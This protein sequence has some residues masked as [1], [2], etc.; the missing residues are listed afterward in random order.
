MSVDELSSRVDEHGQ[1]LN[2]LGERANVQSLRVDSLY[3]VVMGDTAEKVPGLAQRTSDLEGLV[4]EI[5]QWR[6]DTL[7]ISRVVIALLGVTS[8]GT[9]YPIV[10]AIVLAFGI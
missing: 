4:R 7:L 9:W 1:R 5:Q 2:Q 3:R 10:K 6:R 8:I